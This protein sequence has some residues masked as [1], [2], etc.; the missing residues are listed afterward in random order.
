[1]VKL[2]EGGVYLVHGSEIVPA[3]ESASVE[4]LPGK[5]AHQEEAKKGMIA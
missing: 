5:A 1:M 4:Q 2:H 3:S